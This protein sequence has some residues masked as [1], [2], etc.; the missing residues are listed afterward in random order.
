MAKLWLTVKLTA[1]V[2]IAL[3]LGAGYLV[4]EEFGYGKAPAEILI[5][6]LPP[7]YP[8]ATSLSAYNGPH[9]VFQQR[10]PETFDF[11][12]RLGQIGPVDTQLAGETQYP[13]LC[14]TEDSHLGQPL[15]D[16]QQGIGMPIYAEDENQALTD[17]I[18]GYSKDC[19]ITTR[20]EYYYQRE[21]TKRFYPLEDA[22]D[23]IAQIEINGRNIDFIVRLERGAINRFI[24]G[25]AVLASPRDSLAYPSRRLWNGKLIYQFR[26][27]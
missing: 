7:Q 26:G 23:D 2:L 3:F 11:P 6:K 18:V 14:Q 5:T 8:K 9:P 4:Y 15:I 10:K 19:L 24:Y 21:G 25:M 12:I 16:N 27:G 13:F 1:V 22:D 20:A 17:E